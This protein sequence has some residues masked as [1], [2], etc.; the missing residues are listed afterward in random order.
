M[1]RELAGGGETGEWVF[2]A[3]AGDGPA[4]DIEDL[5]NGVTAAA[6]VGNADLARLRPTLASHLLADQDPT[7]VRRLLGL[8]PAESPA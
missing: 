8:E 6:G 5:W 1:L 2:P 4:G 7:I 3:T